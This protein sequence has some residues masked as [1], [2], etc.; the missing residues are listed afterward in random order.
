[1]TS[2]ITKTIFILAAAACLGISRADAVEETC[3]IR[4]GRLIKEALDWPDMDP[5]KNPFWT[6]WVHCAG[7]T[8]DGLF[9]VEKRDK[10]HSRFMGAK[11]A[12][13]DCEFKVVFSCTRADSN[14]S[15][16]NITI[17]DRGRLRFSGDGGRIW[18]ETRKTALPLKTFETPC[19]ANVYDGDLH[20]MAVR[21][22]GSKISFY[23]DDQQVNEQEIDPDV[24]LH[25]WF[26]AF[27][28]APKIKSIKLSADGLSDK[29]ET[30]FKSAGPVITLFDGTGKPGE[31]LANER[32]TRIP[33]RKYEPGK[34]PV[35]RIP[36]MVVTIQG[37]LIVFCEARASKYDWGHIRIVAKRSEDDGRTWGTEIDLSKGR[38]PDNCIGNPAPVVDRQTGRIYS[39]CH[40]RTGTGHADNYAIQN[41]RN[42]LVQ[43]S[44]DD[45]KTWSEPKF[46][47]KQFLREGC[48]H[49]MTGPV[50]GIQLTQGKYKGR[51]VIPGVGP[52]SNYVVYSDDH[53]KTWQAGGSGPANGTVN[54]STAVELLGGDVMV[55]VRRGQGPLNRYSFI[56]PNGGS[57][58]YRK[59]SERYVPDLPDGGTQGTTLRYSWPD[60][61][62][63]GIILYAGP[64]LPTGRVR[65]TLF[66]SYDEGKTWPWKKVIY[67]GGYGYSDIAKLP[68]GR[69]ACVFELNKQDLLFTVFGG[70]PATPPAEPAK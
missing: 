47:I 44:D 23:Y 46:L 12:L 33:G 38:F 61:G 11:S 21:R 13:G 40:F 19:P 70:P 28:S 64:G 3:I 65:G 26:D 17:A 48:D 15:T 25:I 50:H 51:L 14:N 53:G 1:M 62:K 7:E 5:V 2:T 42:V 8:V 55:N 39:I 56:L 4:E 37:T 34:S 10:N 43:Y 29:L 69:I 35:Y 9:V 36:A 57:G 16:P 22:V 20:S 68:D 45:G 6:G 66:A 24:N 52:P 31:I 59:G 54:E 27:R 41:P 30:D 32:A 63:P 60:D 18:M 58:E 49:M 67:E